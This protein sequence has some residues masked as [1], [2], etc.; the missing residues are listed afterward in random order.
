MNDSK[1]IIFLTPKFTLTFF[2]SVSVNNELNFIQ[3]LERNA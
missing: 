2:M 1:S 3:K